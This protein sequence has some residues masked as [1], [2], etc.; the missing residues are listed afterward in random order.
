MYEMSRRLSS[1]K[2]GPKLRKLTRSEELGLGSFV[3]ENMRECV[4]ALGLASTSTF[5]S[6]EEVVLKLRE[7]MGLNALSVEELLTRFM[8]KDSLR[9][10]CEKIL[11]KSGKGTSPVLASR[12]SREWAKASFDPNKIVVKEKSS[13]VKRK[14][15][16]EQKKLCEE[17]EKALETPFE[18]DGTKLTIR[19]RG[20]DVSSRTIQVPS[21]A[22]LKY[23]K[24]MIPKEIEQTKLGQIDLL[25][26]FP[27]RSLSLKTTSKNAPISSFLRTNEL[28]TITSLSSS[29][30]SNR[31]TKKRTTPEKRKRATTNTTTSSASKIVQSSKPK[32]RRVTNANSED[33]VTLL[34][35]LSQNKMK[36]HLETIRAN[37]RLRAAFGKQWKITENQDVRRVDGQVSEMIVHFKFG[38]RKWEKEKVTRMKEDELRAVIRHVLSNLGDA[39]EQLRLS[40]LAQVSP[41]VFWNLC[42]WDLNNP[43]PSLSAVASLEYSLSRLLPDED[44]SFLK[45]RKRKLSTKAKQN[46]K[47]VSEKEMRKAA[48]LIADV[49]ASNKKKKEEYEIV[50]SKQGPHIGVRVRRFFSHGPSDGTVVMYSKPRMKDDVA[51]WRICHDDGDE[52]D[53]EEHELRLAIDVMTKWKSS[54]HPYVHFF[55]FL[56]SICIRTCM[57]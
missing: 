24:A 53:L 51:L 27:P 9:R 26:G 41:R 2:R 14:N 25:S 5:S 50:W 21:Q 31:S 48:K 32:R 15:K 55:I 36:S 35:K 39:K 4:S 7:V 46:Q 12:I 45:S 10:Y 22:P 17:R 11:N 23:L 1:R 8:S 20:R 33:G 42:V 34:K 18:D 40:N 49:A 56:S 52:E 54:G 47:S 37:K 6:Q 28:I 44:W 13:I 16:K 19:F 57:L 30:A 3:K 43:A 38:Q 29:S